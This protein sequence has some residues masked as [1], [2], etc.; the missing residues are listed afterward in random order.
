[1]AYYTKCLTCWGEQWAGQWCWWHFNRSLITQPHS[2]HNWTPIGTTQLWTHAQ[3]ILPGTKGPASY[4]HVGLINLYC[5]VCT[6]SWGRSLG[7]RLG[8]SLIPRIFFGRMKSDHA[9]LARTLQWGFIS[10]FLPSADPGWCTEQHL[11]MSSRLLHWTTCST[12]NSLFQ[13]ILKHLLS[14]LS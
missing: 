1:M 9:R 7:T 5:T 11:V 13:E 4:Q 6:V 14:P 10:L 8:P 3:T 2:M 12:T